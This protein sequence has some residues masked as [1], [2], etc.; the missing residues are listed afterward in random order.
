MSSP[1]NDLRVN[2]VVARHEHDGS[3]DSVPATTSQEHLKTMLSTTEADGL[4]R[5][6]KQATTSETLRF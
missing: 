1:K 2:M 3:Q 4:A 6:L 5:V